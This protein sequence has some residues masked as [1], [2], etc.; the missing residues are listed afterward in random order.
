[1][2]K[3]ILPPAERVEEWYGFTRH[4]FH[5]EGIE[6]WIAEP[7]IPVGD[8]RWSW[9]A[10]WPEAYVKR[11]GVTNLLEHGFYHVHINTHP[12]RGS[13]RCMEIMGRFQDFLVSC[14]FAA[15]CCLVGL[16]W[17]GFFSLRYAQT[18]PEKVASIY[19][20]APVCSAADEGESISTEIRRKEICENFGMSFEELKSSPL[21]PLNSVKVLVDHAIP[22]MAVVGMED[23][24]VNI[25]TNFEIFE[26]RLLALGGKITV[27]RRNFWG[28]HPHGLE[29]DETDK[30][31][32]FH[33]NSLSN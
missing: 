32:A 18:F 17:G 22:I 23:T 30:I 27:I 11:V 33:C 15:K 20:D 9:I 31:L 26:E 29:P 24:S 14:G 8:G 6:A 2:K 19:L 7:H 1:M 13:V 28:H 21:N 3:I 25:H 4:H 16:S 12:M 10:V 5:F